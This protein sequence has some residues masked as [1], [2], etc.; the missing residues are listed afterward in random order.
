VKRGGCVEVTL[1]RELVSEYDG[2]WPVGWGWHGGRVPELPVLLHR[3]GPMIAGGMGC[4]VVEL[5][6]LTPQPTYPTGVGPLDALTRGGLTPGVIWTVAGPPGVG[7]TSLVMQMAAH[8]SQTALV[9]M[10]NDHMATH[11][12]RDRLL[13][14][15]STARIDRAPVDRIDIASWV[16]IPALRCDEPSWFGSE[17]D[18]M[19]IDCFDEMLRP[20]AWPEG[21]MAVLTGRWLRE[22][23]RRSNTAL[24]LTARAD[25]APAKGRPPFE[26]A[27]HSHWA[28]AV[29]DDIAD[30][31]LSL[32]E[33]ED[34]N[35]AF[36]AMARGYGRVGGCM[37]RRTGGGL[38]V[39]PG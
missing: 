22:M 2:Q 25:R 33:S 16:P 36:H 19:I 11:V 29:F 21:R 1:E 14:Y 18:V 3:D 17:Y 15:A 35:V 34:Q 24:V 12:L 23:A 10:A 8:L 31:Q 9:G 4:S 7:V 28:R 32:W 13:M 20:R 6:A 27:W 5:A 39:R 30:V 38:G 37:T 26:R